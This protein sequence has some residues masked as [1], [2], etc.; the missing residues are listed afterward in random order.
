MGKIR[1]MVFGFLVGILTI[2][3]AGVCGGCDVRRARQNTMLV[4]TA[5]LVD[6][7]DKR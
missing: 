7:A 6:V 5:W 2:A 1:I 4:S 3:V